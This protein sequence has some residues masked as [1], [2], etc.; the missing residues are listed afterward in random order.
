MIFKS[1]ITKTQPIS[2]ILEKVY[3]FL[4]HTFF[5]IEEKKASS[6]HKYSKIL[7]LNSI[8]SLFLFL[9]PN[10]KQDKP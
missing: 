6:D 1:D 2:S 7:S 10:S 8:R 4:R 3:N 9:H 5:T